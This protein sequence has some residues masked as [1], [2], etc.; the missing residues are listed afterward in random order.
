MKRDQT[1]LRR[2]VVILLRGLRLRVI[3]HLRDNT[4]GQPH[5]TVIHI[6]KTWMRGH[7]GLRRNAIVR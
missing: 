6:G 3:G 4:I 7:D 5:I 1:R 2:R